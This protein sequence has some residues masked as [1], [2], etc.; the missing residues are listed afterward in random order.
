MITSD[1]KISILFFNLYTVMGGGELAVYN[2]L[3]EIDR[4]RFRPVMMFN[5]RGTFAEKAE[6]IGIE[7]VVLNYPVIMLKKLINP[8]ILMEANRASK[9]IFNYLSKNRIDVIHCTD[10]LSLLLIA[11]SARKLKIPVIYN[12]IF[13]YEWTRL[14]LFNILAPFVVS[15]IITN[16][17]AVKRDLI[18]R[19][20]F[21]GKEISTVYPGLDMSVFRPLRGREKNILTEEFHI[22]P[23][24]KLIGI[25]GRIDPTKGQLT[26]V[27]AA[28]LLLQ[29]RKD[30]HFFVV[31]G[32]LNERVIPSLK[33]YYDDTV[34]AYQ[35]LN[36]Q[37]N[38]TFLGDRHEVPEIMRS[39]DLVV[40]P[41]VNE[42]FGM[43][44]LEA[45][46][47][48]SKVIASRTV[49]ALEVVEDF[50]GVFTTEPDD[51][52]A[53]ARKFTEALAYERKINADIVRKR[54]EDLSWHN[55]A[56]KLEE[57][58]LKISQSKE[59]L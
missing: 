57:W 30:I 51:P 20:F 53:L 46:A 19:T 2:Q 14:L 17:Y 43:V 47:S 18:R 3:K 28:S 41:S 8:R 1:R 37:K 52:E 11:R 10:V 24:V 9:D 50:P 26:F 40:C 45:V 33:R 32:L 44:V 7:T 12:V 49:G 34:K 56:V 36:L 48:G 13:F 59:L 39:L 58:Y 38:V 4:S 31:G 15:K 27:R 29:K 25:V 42:G 23:D 55:Y 16:S 22:A 6:S 35:K 21:V 54:L 5:S